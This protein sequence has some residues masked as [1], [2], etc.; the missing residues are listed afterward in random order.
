MYLWRVGKWYLSF[1]LISLPEIHPYLSFQQ[2]CKNCLPPVTVN[3]GEVELK[4]L[5]SGEREED[6]ALP[7]LFL[8]ITFSWASQVD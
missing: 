1:S 8:H 3:K 7:P 4:W 6:E 5:V 2:Y